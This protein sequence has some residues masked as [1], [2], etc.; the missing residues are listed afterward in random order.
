MNSPN[1]SP[2]RRIGLV[3]APL[4]VPDGTDLTIAGYRAP[5]TAGC[6]APPAGWCAACDAAGKTLKRDLRSSG[7]E[8]TSN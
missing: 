8:R 3:A 4:L 7:C 1:R 2:L 5:G 6:R